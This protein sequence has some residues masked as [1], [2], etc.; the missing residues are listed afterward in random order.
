M[1]NQH[2][3][4][5]PYEKYFKRMFDVFCGLAALLVFW[6]LYIIVAVLVRIKLGSPVLF[7]QERPGKNSKIFKLYKFRT[8]TDTRDE[9]GNL[10]PDEV[11]LTK[12]GRALRTTSLDEL[13]EVFNI[14][15]G[16][17]SLV[18]P[19]PLTIQYLPYYSEE[20]RHRHDVRPGLSGLAQ[21]NGRNFIDWDHRLAF[22]VQYVKKITFI[23]DLRIILQTALKFV[24]KEDIAVDT[25][26]VEPNFAEE[27]RLKMQVK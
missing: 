6:W 22:D 7:K 23:G 1:N 13:P 5:G 24:K 16:E 18:G 21:V 9:N 2:K 25:N 3:P 27:R 14:L 15:K 20:E 26:K 12:F 17:M 10:L 4:Y 8:M 19:R 11:R